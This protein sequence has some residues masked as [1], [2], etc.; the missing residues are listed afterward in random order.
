[1]FSGST[2]VSGQRDKVFNESG[3]FLAQRKKKRTQRA[4]SSMLTVFFFQGWFSKKAK[5]TFFPHFSKKK[6]N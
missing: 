4:Q 6:L 2:G 5:V 3:I 1:L